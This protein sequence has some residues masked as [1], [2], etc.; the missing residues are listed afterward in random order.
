[1]NGP[2]STGFA[3]EE[4]AAGL[5]RDVFGH[6]GFRPGQDRV[7]ASVLAGRDT[8][9]VMPTGGGKSLCYQIPALLGMP[10]N[11]EGLTLVVCP[12]VSLMKDQR[13][14]L[15]EKLGPGA[16]RTVI[17]LHASLSAAERR[18]AE[19]AILSGEARIL[20]ASPERL[21]S[22]E[23]CLLLKR[24]GVSLLVVDEAHCISEW[25]HDFRPDYLFVGEA[26]RDLAPKGGASAEGKAGARPP[27]LAL[28]ATAD[29]RV[30]ADVAALLG[31]GPD[32]AEVTTG[33]DRPNLAYSVERIGGEE[34]RLS[35]VLGILAS[36]EKPAIVYAHTRRQTEAL[37]DGISASGQPC[38]AYHAGM[39]QKDR[40]AVQERFMA[41]KTAVIC[42]TVAFGMGIDKPDVRTVVHASLPSS[43]P[44]Y[45]QEAGRAGR[46]GRE[47]SCTVL[48]AEGEMH[49]R[50]RL[51]LSSST[52]PADAHLFFD[53]ILKRA[54][55]EGKG[56]SGGAPVRLQLP[57]K[58]LFSLGGLPAERAQDAFAAL[59]ASGRIK[60]RYN[61]WS[62][63]RARRTAG[64]TRPP[65]ASSAAGRLLG[66][67][68]EEPARKNPG[69]WASHRLSD[70]AA[71]AGVA[72]PTAQVL[73]YR[74][75]ALGL[76]EVS[77]RGVVADVLVKTAPLGSRE[78]RE[79]ESRLS[80]RE[81]SALAHLDAIEGYAEGRSC[82]RQRI[83]DHFEGEGRGP[84][85]AP[86]GTC[87]VCKRGHGRGPSPSDP[88]SGPFGGPLGGLLRRLRGLVS[89]PR[90]P[91]PAPGAR[92]A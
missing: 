90:E 50:R 74:L 40:D 12:L 81:R 21:R 60:R 61:L 43:L 36:R 84:V 91:R 89:P 38:E 17:A 70:L 37:A 86:C 31:M 30:K 71:R 82:R 8:L 25:G 14:G 7:V 77:G 62:G 78:K 58:E 15:L 9:A 2:A 44:A 52:P 35:R 88:S 45:V 26:A 59:E 51:V 56:P 54:A 69:P 47:A 13:E 48:F 57:D 55:G 72:P 80:A 64:G 63:V 11:P 66:L 24:R 28:T 46:D 65:D 10:R 27:I 1:M 76:A 20:F 53:A 68:G 75:S 33:F 19:D 39:P 18:E 73:L 5:L 4:A 79:L 83:V 34:E 22:L 6:E 3:A 29:D 32:H 87:D 92:A 16:G 41:G 49:R 42:A 85:V 67:L 23:F